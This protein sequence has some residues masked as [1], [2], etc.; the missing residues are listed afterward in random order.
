MVFVVNFF[1][2][3]ALLQFLEEDKSRVRLLRTSYLVEDNC[4]IVDGKRKLFPQIEHG[5]L[6]SENGKFFGISVSENSFKD[7]IKVA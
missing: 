6:A 2:T 3:G 7:I 4:C 5:E 1:Q